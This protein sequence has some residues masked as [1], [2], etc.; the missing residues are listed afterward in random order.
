M[1]GG[2]SFWEGQDPPDVKVTLYHGPGRV[3]LIASNLTYDE[4]AA[5]NTLAT[6]RLGIPAESLKLDRVL[7]NQP[8]P[9]TL[10]QGTIRGTV[11]GGSCLMCVLHGG[12]SPR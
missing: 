8:E 4:V 11:R 7:E 2:W 10:S 1:I 9:P 5:T 6:H 3:L 12:G